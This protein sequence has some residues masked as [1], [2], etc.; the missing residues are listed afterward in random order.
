MNREVHRDT[1]PMLYARNCFDFGFWGHYELVAFFEGIGEVNT[2]RIRR[3]FFPFPRLEIIKGESVTV[4]GRW[5][6]TLATIGRYCGRLSTVEMSF[7][8]SGAFDLRALFGFDDPNQIIKQVI[9]LMDA[10]FKAVLSQPQI[11]VEAS[12]EA[13]DSNFLLQMQRHGWT[14]KIVGLSDSGGMLIVPFDDYV[15]SRA[16]GEHQTLNQGQSG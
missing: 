3:V 15:A 11:I 14:V 5:F 4:G 7:K 8:A 12:K 10:Q 1:A 16:T 2:N 6:P 9:G 13:W